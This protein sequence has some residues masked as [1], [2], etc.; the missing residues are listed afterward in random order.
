VKKLSMLTQILGI[1]ALLVTVT[2][3][4][5]TVAFDLELGTGASQR[6]EFLVLLLAVLVTLLANSFLLRRRFEPLERLISAMEQADL[7]T[8]GGR[9]DSGE[10]G[11]LEVQR[12]NATFNR[13]LDRLE[14]ERREGARGVVRAQEQERQR[15]AQDLHDEVNQALTAILLRLEAALPDAPPALRRE[16][17]TTKA[18]TSRAMEQ[19]LGLARELRPA[20]LDDHGLL[21]ALRTQVRDFSEQTGIDAEFRRQGVVPRLTD[22]QQL[23]IYRVTQESLSNV[24]QHADAGR[25]LVE[26]SSIGRIMLR[27]SDDGRGVPGGAGGFTKGREGGL[28]LSGMYERAVLVGGNLSIYSTEGA[29]TTVTLTMR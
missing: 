13:M 7:T 4:V 27:I 29:G 5:A 1:N 14:A 26:L 25:V 10:G 23:A 11:S 21:A 19:L 22:E 16:L 28:G 8:T 24:A 20:A 3:F 17:E 15:L 9:A 2:V 18:L 6:R 12:L